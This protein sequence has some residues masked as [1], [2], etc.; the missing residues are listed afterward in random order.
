MDYSLIHLLEKRALDRSD[1]TVTPELRLRLR[2][3]AI[4]R[5]VDELAANFG[6][7]TPAG[8]SRRRYDTLL[9][10][11]ARKLANFLTGSSKKLD[12]GAPSSVDE[13]QVDA[14]L[15]A[16]ILGLTVEERK[17]LGIPKT[18]LWYIQ[19]DAS[20]GVRRLYR[21]TQSLLSVASRLRNPT[22]IYRMAL[23]AAHLNEDSTSSVH[24][25]RWV[26]RRPKSGVC[27]LGGG[28]S[29]FSNDRDV[30]FAV[31]CS[32]SRDSASVPASG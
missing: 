30:G 13:V 29:P 23:R 11:D 10:D 1:F 21:K 6:R 3:T 31:L 20:K 12:F 28:V 15:R 32:K 22:V 26:T 8:G 16:R 4:R 19:K 5:I 27:R 18:T 9:A 2:P 7:K 14:E 25:G 24:E 17:K